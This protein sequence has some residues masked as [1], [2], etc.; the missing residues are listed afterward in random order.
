VG[1]LADFANVLRYV[2]NP[3]PLLLDRANLRKRSYIVRTRNGVAMEIRP[4]HGDRYTFYETL[5][6]NS[7]LRQGQHLRPGDTVI[8]IGANIGC[9]SV[10][11]A[12]AV[13]PTGRVLAVEPEQS[14]FESLRRNVRLNRCENIDARRLAIGGSSGEAELHVGVKMLFNSIYAQVGG[15]KEGAPA[16]GTGSELQRVPMSTLENLMD[17]AE[18]ERCDYLKI[19][20]EGAE[21]DIFREMDERTANRIDQITMEIHRIPGGEPEA[22]RSRLTDLGFQQEFASS[23]VYA[24]R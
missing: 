5:V 8:D 12:R 2:K 21:F 4:R 23:L 20:C 16:H 1:A 13:G 22:L 10:L 17:D 14:T 9:F 6:M 3:L 19:D 11:A 24:W 7:Y 15:V 18:V